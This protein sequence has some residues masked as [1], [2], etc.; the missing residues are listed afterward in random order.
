MNLTTAKAMGA[1]RDRP[2]R[3]GRGPGTGNGKTSGK[4][5]KGQKSR[6]GYKRRL[7]FEGGQM[8]LYRRMPRRGFN[9]KNF[10][11]RYTIINVQDLECFESGADVDLEKIIEVGLT[12]LQT[13]RLKVLGKGNLTKALTV[14]AHKCSGSAKEKI[15]A[16]GGKVVIVAEEPVRK[17]VV[18]E[19][20]DTGPAPEEDA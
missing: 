11:T 2:K 12:S 1:R 16:A 19:L 6:S 15:E 17:P 9:N 14:M 18:A 8:P 3:V 5:H 13:P 4:G 7:W 10:T 20:T